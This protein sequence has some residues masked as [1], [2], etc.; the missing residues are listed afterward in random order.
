MPD[1]LGRSVAITSM[2]TTKLESYGEIGNRGKSNLEN[3]FLDI[4]FHI[5]LRININKVNWSVEFLEKL[6]YLFC[7]LAIN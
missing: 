2:R 4:G 5:L 7:W 3:K 1:L 6:R